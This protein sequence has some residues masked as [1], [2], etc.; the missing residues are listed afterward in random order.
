MIFIVIVLFMCQKY[1]QCLRISEQYCSQQ[2]R[3][4]NLDTIK[5]ILTLL[6]KNNEDEP[7]LVETKILVSDFLLFNCTVTCELDLLEN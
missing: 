7:V 4:T 3:Y 2:F 1:V 5:K 6:N